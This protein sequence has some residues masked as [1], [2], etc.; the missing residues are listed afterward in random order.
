[1]GPELPVWGVLVDPVLLHVGQQIQLAVRLEKGLEGWT[2][3]RR[4]RGAI[5][6][7]VGGV[8]GRLG[9]ILAATD[10]AD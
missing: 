6:S 4:H 10:S 2:C 8:G 5:S 7:A 3:V 9:V 1:M